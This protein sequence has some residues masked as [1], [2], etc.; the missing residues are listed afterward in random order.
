M[1]TTAPSTG[2]L[3]ESS[4]VTV[5]FL[6]RNGDTEVVLTH[7]RQPSRRVRSFHRYGWNG[8]LRKL[9]GVLQA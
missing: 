9:D 3:R 1:L 7:E 5:E 4:T 2:R 6:E 8:S